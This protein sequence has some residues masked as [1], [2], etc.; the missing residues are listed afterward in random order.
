M[1]RSSLWLGLPLAAWTM[2][3]FV[4]IALISLL[5]NENTYQ[6]NVLATHAQTRARVIM[7]TAHGAVTTPVFTCWHELVSIT[8][9]ARASSGG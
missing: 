9:A 2:S 4:V 6:V 3:A 1:G 5:S 7:T 8:N